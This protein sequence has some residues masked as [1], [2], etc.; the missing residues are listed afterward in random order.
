MILSLF[1]TNGNPTMA[2]VSR[3]G[4]RIFAPSLKKAT[5][6]LPKTLLGE[7][8]SWTQLLGG[9]DTKTN[10]SL[11]EEDVPAGEGTPV[12]IHPT[13]N[14][15]FYFI[16]GTFKAV[17][18][19]DV[20]DVQAGDCVYV[21]AGSVHAWCNVGDTPGKLLFGFTPSAKGDKLTQVF[22]D[23]PTM[24]PETLKNDYDLVIVGPPVTPSSDILKNG[25]T[26]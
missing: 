5:Q 12:H 10:M 3:A 9:N 25:Y 6:D 19:Q 4:Q 8:R 20:M 23:L 14:E 24:D 7:S 13:E 1:H 22:K 16:Q 2:F 21:P 18:D 26:S 15:F 11:V 17:V